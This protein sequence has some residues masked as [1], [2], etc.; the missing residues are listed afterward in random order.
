MVKLIF[1]YIYF[2]FLFVFIFINKS[3][4][5]VD[6]DNIEQMLMTKNVTKKI[7]FFESGSNVNYL[8]NFLYFLIER[9][10]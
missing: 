6:F 8:I 7:E 10:F 2:S 4:E 5:L 9:F 3:N 1:H